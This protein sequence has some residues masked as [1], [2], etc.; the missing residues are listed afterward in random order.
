MTVVEFERV[1][2]PQRDQ[3]L[4]HIADTCCQ[5]FERTFC[6]EDLGPCDE[7]ASDMPLSELCV[8]CIDI[9]DRQLVCRRCSAPL[10]R[11]A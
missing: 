5:P 11:V 10:R 6:G 8:V 4:V 3:L 2:A 7:A 9:H 1:E